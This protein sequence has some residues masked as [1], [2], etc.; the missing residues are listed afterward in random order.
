MIKSSYLRFFCLLVLPLL[1]A[2]APAFAAKAV[3]D[4]EKNFSRQTSKHYLVLVRGNQNLC[5]KVSERMEWL[6]AQYSEIFE[7]LYTK[8]LARVVVLKDSKEYHQYIISK[9]AR[10]AEWTAGLTRVM[11]D[12]MGTTIEM[13]TYQQDDLLRV[14]S[15]EGLHQ[16]LRLHMGNTMPI[17]LNEGLACYFEGGLKYS[18]R[19]R[20]V[21]AHT[22]RP[23]VLEWML[24]MGPQAFY[25][26]GGITYTLAWSLVTYLAGEA[27]INDFSKSLRA[28]RS[29]LASGQGHGKMSASFRKFMGDVR[30]GKGAVSAFKKR[31]GNLQKVQKAWINWLEG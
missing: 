22:N 11:I 26:K 10:G 29:N 6:I 23:D 17:W 20:E 9:G 19:A 2:S 5:R 30:A 12:K 18:A 14:L 16:F 31:F 28:Q 8:P 24:S 15:H 1:A 4:D 27:L 7:N 13:D 3:Y 25:Q 21:L